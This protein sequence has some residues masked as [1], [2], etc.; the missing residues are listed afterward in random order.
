MK[1]T[2]LLWIYTDITENRFWPAAHRKNMD[3][4]E[5]GAVEMR[6][7]TI[8]GILLASAGMTLTGSAEN[9]V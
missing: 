8:Q 4:S 5:L 2:E 7:K 1:P 6:R 9:Y 3:A